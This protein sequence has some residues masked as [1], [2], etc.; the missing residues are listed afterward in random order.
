MSPSSIHYSTFSYSTSQQLK[1]RIRIT[2]AFLYKSLAGSP[3]DKGNKKQTNT[4][5]FCS[6][7]NTPSLLAQP[8]LP[9]TSR[10]ASRPSGCLQASFT[11]RSESSQCIAVA[12]RSWCKAYTSQTQ[13]LWCEWTLR[14]ETSRHTF[15]SS[16]SLCCS[17]AAACRAFSCRC[18]SSLAST[19][20][21][22][23][24]TA[25]NLFSS[26]ASFFALRSRPGVC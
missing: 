15:S 2:K 1:L 21:G 14:R 4:A 8:L 11:D 17:W 12:V 13:L 9:S 25:E 23:R 16:F 5:T 3:S 10:E 19:S 22:S 26:S 7:T 24:R 6:K 18:S 20:P